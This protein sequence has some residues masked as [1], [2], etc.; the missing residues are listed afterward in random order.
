MAARSSSAPRRAGCGPERSGPWAWPSVTWSPSSPPSAGRQDAQA[1]AGAGVDERASLNLV[2]YAVV[3]HGI[4]VAAQHRREAEA[5]RLMIARS[6]A[7][8]THY[9]DAERDLADRPR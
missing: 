3:R 4:L 7:E 5:L 8:R 2:F 6:S 1:Y 9:A